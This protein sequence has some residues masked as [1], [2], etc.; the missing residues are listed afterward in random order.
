MSDVLKKVPLDL[1]KDP[2]AAFYAA[3]SLTN[4]NGILLTERDVAISD[5]VPDLTR[6][7]A[8]TRFTM[9]PL[10]GSNKVMGDPLTRWYWRWDMT[11]VM[12]TVGYHDNAISYTGVPAEW[13]AGLAHGKAVDMVNMTLNTT[14]TTDYTTWTEIHRDADQVV[15]VLSI[16]DG[17]LTIFGEIEITVDML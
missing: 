7:E 10:P 3:L 11:D 14:L 6:P 16:N 8:N 15:G 17:V 9:T 12:G 13:A 5:V 1:T 2:T 4:S